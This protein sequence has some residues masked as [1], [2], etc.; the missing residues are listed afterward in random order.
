MSAPVPKHVL[1]LVLL[2]T[3]VFALTLP[4]NPPS[5]IALLLGI[6]KAESI[7]KITREADPKNHL[8][9]TYQYAVEG[10]TYNAKGYGPDG[11]EMRLGE[12]VRLFYFPA[13]PQAATIV[14]EEQ[15]TEYLKDGLMAGFAMATFITLAV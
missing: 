6:K 7:A 12:Q 5:F 1:P 13:Y 11:K 10:R 4:M 15:Q 8:Y 2:W 3:I 9:V 14:T